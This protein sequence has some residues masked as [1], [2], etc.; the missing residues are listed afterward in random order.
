MI[1]PLTRGVHHVGLAVPDLAAVERFF[2]DALGWTVTGGVPACP[3]VF[4]SD[5]TT[6]VTLWRVADP[7]TAAPFDRRAQVGLHHLALKVAHM[8]SE[9]RGPANPVG[10]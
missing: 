7:D 5:G 4:V 2:V 10:L 3:S 6:M 9:R 8:P 1:E